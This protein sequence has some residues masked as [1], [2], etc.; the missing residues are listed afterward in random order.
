MPQTTHAD[1]H[2]DIGGLEAGQRA[3]EN[4]LDRLE[5]LIEEGFREV[6]AEL[7]E[8]KL[9]ERERSALEKAGIWLSGVIGAVAVIIIQH[10][11]K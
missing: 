5:N 9:R 3:M 11:W 1:L 7:S 8:L 4:R 6:R 10:F 2:R